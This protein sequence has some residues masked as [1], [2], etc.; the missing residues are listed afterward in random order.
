[1]PVHSSLFLL[2]VLIHTAAAEP[3]DRSL[4]S[5]T[6]VTLSYDRA[7]DFGP[8]TPGT[9]TA[10]WQEA[11]D[12]CVA[13]HLDLYIKGGWGGRKPIYHISDTIRIPASQDFKIDGGVYV[14]NWTGPDVKDLLVIDSGMDCHYSFGILVYGGQGAALRVKPENPVPID[15]VAVFIDS[16]ISASSIADPHPFQRGRR[17]HGAGVVFDTSKAP[18]ANADFSFSAILNFA[19]CIKM[20]SDGKGFTNNGLS[21]SNLHTNADDSTLLRVGRQS[22]QNTLRL[23]IGV[24]QGATGVTGIEVLGDNNR[25]EINTR[26]RFSARRTLVFKEPAEGNQVNLIHAVASPLELVTDQSENPTN[27]LTHTGAPAPIRQMTLKS[28]S[29]TY[30][31]R[32]FPATVRLSGGEISRVALVR[33]DTRL[34][35][36]STREILLGVG[37]ELE[38]ESD[39]PATLTVVPFKSR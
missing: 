31:Q 26:G 14:L 19:T 18:I 9:L 17:E 16:D 10:G 6:C 1:M 35:Y 36:G 38:V 33:G 29:T 27:Q 30:T 13:N 12:H 21:C 23:R 34:D 32:L 11:V 4:I 8:Q 15:N 20:P 5:P 39:N 37:D 25:L 2:S 28:G 22:C 24:D 3:Q 7:G